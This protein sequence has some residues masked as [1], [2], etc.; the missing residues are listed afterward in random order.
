MRLAP[1]LY[2]SVLTDELRAEIE[3]IRERVALADLSPD[4][5][6]QALARHVH[7]RLVRALLDLPEADRIGSQIKLT[8]A[9]LDVIKHLSR[10]SGVI[11]GDRLTAPASVLMQVAELGGLGDG[12]APRPSLSLGQSD[13]L[14][15]GPRDLRLGDELRRELPSADRVDVLVSF[16]KWTGLRV[17]QPELRGLLERRPGCVRVLTTSYMGA[18]EPEAI[19]ALIELGADVRVS[20]DTRRTRLHAKAWLFH[21]KSGFSTAV[22]GS[23]NLSHAALLDGCEWNVRLTAVDNGVIL[24]KLSVTFDQYW[25]DQE[26][27]PYDRARLV[28]GSLRRDAERDALAQVGQLR[29]HPYQQ[30]VLDALAL[31]RERGHTRNL[32]VAATGTGKTVIAALDYARLHSTLPRARLLFVAHRE[33]IL[34]Q[35]LATFRVAVRDGYFGELLVGRH[36]PV[37]G[38]HVFASIQSL[39]ADRIS[40]LDP[41]HYDVVIVDEFHHAESKSYRGLLE[42]LRP[43]VLLGLTAT[44]DRADGRPLLG[45]FDGRMA[46]NLRLWDALDLG[47]LAPFQYFGIYDGTDLTT[48]DFR[49]GRY[50]INSLERVYTADDVRTKAVLHAVGAYIRRPSQMRALGFCVSVRHAEYTAESFRREGFAAV[51]VHGESPEEERK[52]ALRALR[53]G[54]LQVVFTVD[55]FNEGVDIPSVDTVLFLR[56]TESATVFLQQL[57][58]GLRHHEGKSCLTVLDF[59]GNANRRFRFDTRYKA[60]LGGGTRS[61]V[62]SAIEDGFPRLPAGC[63]IRLEREAQQAILRNVSAQLEN[64]WAALVA[65]LRTTGD[66]GLQEFLKRADLELGDLYFR[67]ERSYTAL[68]HASGLRPGPLPEAEAVQALPRLLHID[69]EVRLTRWRE[70]LR[71]PHP[72]IHAGPDP[73]AWMLFASLGFARRPVAEVDAALAAVWDNSDLRAE[74]L[75]LLDEL[76]DQRRRPTY[77]ERETPL[78]THATYSRDEV[79]AAMLDAPNGK[80]RLLQS[81]VHFHE[82][83]RTDIFFVT[84]EKDARH[85]SSTTQYN[86][87]PISPTSFHWESQSATA[88]ESPTGRRYRGLS[89]LPRATWLF[90]RQRKQDSRGITMPYLFL[91]PAQFVS[92]E[93]ERPMRIVWELERAMPA[94]FFAESK[95]AAG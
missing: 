75:A 28:E 24:K 63:E 32:V 2:E 39:H 13:L 58:R 10:D 89:G 77:S 23:S 71:S 44:P 6:P 33:E 41:E 55:L 9:L 64:R 38:D 42:H 72:P 95:I 15:N 49:A 68:L 79:M 46:A 11:D 29:A 87:Y 76:D 70:W 48:V 7:D 80:L 40:T 14:V 62:R 31:E 88:S 45:W 8:N 17:I 37:A 73:L 26:F 81:G 92:S 27:E 83:S 59:V 67:P 43:K 34:Q 86:D 25:A 78:R 69:D 18:T 20:Y 19:E 22:V 82:R 74:L 52:A 53:D 84:L 30:E 91:G 16:L 36:R 54:T 12:T 90:V 3:T 66:V 57:G 50:D 47:L 35:S 21:R 93:G 51:A 5:A 60:I 65:D 1:G 61:E 94:G 85:F 4:A 56:P